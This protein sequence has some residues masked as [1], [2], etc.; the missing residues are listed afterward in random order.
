MSTLEQ[1]YRTG[2]VCSAVKC[3]FYSRVQARREISFSTNWD[4]ETRKKETHHLNIDWEGAQ[5]A[6]RRSHYWLRLFL[7]VFKKTTYRRF[8]D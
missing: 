3:K 6:K 4:R 2:V 8:S 7:W 5:N 1:K